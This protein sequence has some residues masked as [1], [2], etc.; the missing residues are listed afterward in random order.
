MLALPLTWVEHYGR[1][2]KLWHSGIFLTM[3]I[4]TIPFVIEWLYLN[5]TLRNT[6]LW[7]WFNIWQ[8]YLWKSWDNLVI[9][10]FSRSGAPGE[11]ERGFFTFL[12]KWNPRFFILLNC[13]PIWNLKRM[14]LWGISETTCERR[15]SEWKL[16]VEE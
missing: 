14:F 9:V 13:N 3:T 15:S 4:Q 7:I 16:P 2:T 1:K 8:I 6:Q 12:W 11:K 10:H 5:L